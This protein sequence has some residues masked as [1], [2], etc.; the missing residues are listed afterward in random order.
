M[1][2]L[3]SILWFART[4]KITLFYL[5]L[6]Q[7]KEYQ[8]KRFL[9]HFRTEK[10]K[11]LILSKLNFVKVLSIF[12]FLF[13]PATFSYLLFILYLAESFKVLLDISRKRLK[14][15]VLTK[16]TTVLIS[17]VIFLEV[18]FLLNLSVEIGTIFW[19]PFWLL[20]VDILAPL[21]ISIIVLIFQFPTVFLR[22]QI[23]KKAKKKREQFGNLL[24]IGITGSYGKT[25]TKE[26]LAAIL[27]EKFKVLKTKA[28]QNSEIGIS[29]C[30]LSE[31][32]PEHEIF[33]VEMGA[34]G[35]GGIKLLADIVKPKIGIL[36]G[37]N[38]QHLALFGS[39]ENIV[40]TKYELIES[41]PP[42]GIA[43]FNGN[44]KYCL[45]LYKKTEAFSKKL[46]NTFSAIA[47]NVLQ[48]NIWAEDIKVEKE[49]VLFRAVSEDGNSANFK[50]NLL[51]GQNVENI[52]LAACCAK[53]LGMNL[54][55]ISRACLR[56]R[57]RQGAMKFLRKD[58]LIV[59]DASFSANP[60]GVIADLDYLK[61][62]SGKK[63]IVMPCLIE[64]GK[65]SKEVHKKIGRKIAEVC[66]LAIITTKE[67]FKD[68]KEGAVE[69]GMKEENILFLKRPKKNIEKVREF[70][71]LGDVVLLEG[72]VPKGM[73]GLLNSL[74]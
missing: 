18:V 40:K 39:Q 35:L 67:R 3:L 72:R 59:L 16:K 28:H 73:F 25:S 11:Q 27:S 38:E 46:C 33:I 5:Y 23:I 8:I 70:F 65:A 4:A 55:E 48:A 57:P 2:F 53:G 31:L 66:D 69:N 13:H 24:V 52:L 6:W 32:K 7:L 64:L 56:I 43:I 29:Q 49:S 36:T 30:I 20:I 68:I 21:I 44:N 10:G 34:Y 37:I 62:Y 51:G 54:E 61:I 47:E 50:V 15:P 14:K 17:V 12:I 63:V 9:D 45:E 71:G 22:N 26:F 60:K 19:F 42:D 41:L 74:E 1:F 58:G